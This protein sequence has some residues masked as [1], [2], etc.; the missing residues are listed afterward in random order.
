[1]GI[2]GRS[3]MSRTR[4]RE[5]TSSQNWKDRR[6]R[7][8]ATAQ[9]TKVKK[10]E[11]SW[12]G[13][14]AGSRRKKCCE[15][16]RLVLRAHVVSQ[17]S[18]QKLEI[19]FIQD[20]KNT[21]R[22]AFIDEKRMKNMKLR[23]FFRR[24]EGND[25]GNENEKQKM[26]PAEGEDFWEGETIGLLTTVAT[27]ALIASAIALVLTLA[28]PVVQTMT[29]SFPS[30]NAENAYP[31]DDFAQGED[32]SDFYDTEFSLDEDDALSVDNADVDKTAQVSSEITE[33]DGSILIEKETPDLEAA[34]AE[35]DSAIQDVT[36]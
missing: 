19:K 32:E 11:R 30:G 10:W 34:D 24:G 13:C 35:F 15:E 23:A 28:Q 16:N 5:C 21:Y 3:G 1:M 4:A 31:K 2:D 18:P 27:G 29:A 9:M 36:E 33:L 25:A 6:G 12:L 8:V 22:F 7:Q 14:A 17:L 20:K 26:L